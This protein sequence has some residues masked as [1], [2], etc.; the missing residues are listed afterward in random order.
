[1]SFLSKLTIKP[2]Y[3]YGAS[4]ID[5]HHTIEYMREVVL[6]ELFAQA[7]A[8]TAFQKKEKCIL[9]NRQGKDVVVRNKFGINPDG[10]VAIGVN[11]GHYQIVL[12][13]KDGT[14]IVSENFDQLIQD[15]KTVGLAIKAGELDEQ[16]RKAQANYRNRRKTASDDEEDED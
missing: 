10:T 13:D 3:V 16:I 7:Q 11:Y 1:M 6:A 4:S 15:I 9:K 12:D 14:I 2:G 8:I 5:R